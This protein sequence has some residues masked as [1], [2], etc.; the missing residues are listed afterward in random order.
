MKNRAMTADG[1]YVFGPGSRMLVDTP[2]CVAQAVLTRLRLYRG[3]WF[4]DLREGLDRD[5][6]LGYGTQATR[7]I[8][9]KAR[10]T[11]TPGVQALVAYESRVDVRDFHVAA[12]V[13]TYYGQAAINGTL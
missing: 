1:D 10:I 8:E 2:A 3:E 6:V 13:E 4:L 9:I 11:G 12:I 5:L 7:D